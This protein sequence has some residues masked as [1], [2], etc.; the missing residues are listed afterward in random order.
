M[1]YHEFETMFEV[2]LQTHTETYP[3]AVEYHRGRFNQ[4]IQSLLSSIKEISRTVG[5]SV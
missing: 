2:G 5:V 1:R 3:H 4:T